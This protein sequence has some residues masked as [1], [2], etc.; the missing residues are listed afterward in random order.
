VGTGLGLS[1]VLSLVREHG[2]QVY[3]SSPRGSGAVFVVELP[4]AEQKDL[5]RL[6]ALKPQYQPSLVSQENRSFLNAAKRDGT[7]RVLVVEDEP[8][9]AQ[10]ISDV[11]RDEGF[12]IE[13]LLD[14]RDATER[15]LRESFDLIVCDMKMPN[16]DGQSLYESL[17]SARKFLQRRFL[18]VTGD[19]LGARTH[20]FLTKNELPYVEKPFRMEEL[21]EKVHQVLQPA[22]SLGPHRATPF[23]KNRATTG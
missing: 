1:I 19:V 2:G 17:P 14:G 10:L 4:A 8:T 3:V 18:F 21:L 22:G 16:L 5:K 9:V 15:L 13:I 7:H 11:L 6:G 23:R 20:E 12:E